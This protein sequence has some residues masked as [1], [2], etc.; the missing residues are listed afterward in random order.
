[1]EHGTVRDLNDGRETAMQR[2]GE[3]SCRS[4]EAA[5]GQKEA[6]GPG[7]GLFPPPTCVHGPV[8]AALTPVGGGC[9]LRSTAGAALGWPQ[10]PVPLLPSLGICP[11]VETGL[12]LH[13]PQYLWAPWQVTHGSCLSLWCH[14]G[15]FLERHPWTFS[16][17]SISEPLLVSTLHLR[18]TETASSFPNTI[19]NGA[20]WSLNICSRPLFL[21][22]TFS[23]SA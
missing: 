9:G 20:A 15:P 10:C 19:N 7:H 1:M 17:A 18:V 6:R 14:D 13:C 21:L 3:G 11:S 5:I 8:K 12:F 22:E 4:L 23:S 16:T 2:T